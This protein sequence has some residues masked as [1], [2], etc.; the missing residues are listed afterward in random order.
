M[1]R[2]LLLGH[3][4]ARASRHIPE[5]TIASFELCLQQSCDGFEFDV[6]RS[7][8]GQAVICHDPV[9][10][11]MEIASTPAMVL[12]LPTLEGVLRVLASRAFIDI[13]LKVSGLEQATVALLQEHAAQQRYVVS[14]FLPEVL[15]TLHDLDTAI[16][17]GMICDRRDELTRWQELPV[18]WV[19]PQF[20]LAD[21][22][23]IEQV[24]AAG[25]RVMVW[26]VNREDQMRQFADWG[27]DGI[28]SDETNLA[29]Q[30][31]AVPRRLV[32]Y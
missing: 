25:K 17:L 18:A 10:R 14:S 9:V 19:I 7:A 28:I 24:Q 31:L 5:N 8:D 20:K 22:A 3:R 30:V 12:G 13:E 1:K 21:K 2:P 16:P 26:T 15:V 4:G 6:R 11:G 23:L 27:A 32:D 29:A